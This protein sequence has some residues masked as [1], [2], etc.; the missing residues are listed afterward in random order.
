MITGD[1]NIN[2]RLYGFRTGMAIAAMFFYAIIFALRVLYE[3]YKSDPLPQISLYKAPPDVNA[4]KERVKQLVQN[5]AGFDGVICDG[6]S[7]VFMKS[8]GP[9][10]AVKN[11]CFAVE[12]GKCFGLLGK[13][14]AGKTTALNVMTG[15][16]PATSG[17]GILNSVAT[18]WDPTGVRKQSG[19]CPQFQT[20]WLHFTVYQHLYLA[21]S[22]KG[23]PLCELDAEINRLCLEIGLTPYIS[24]RCGHLSGGNKRKLMLA[25]ALIGGAKVLF[26]DEPSA[27][28]D[29]VARSAIMEFIKS[30]KKDRVIIL[31]THQMEETEWLCDSIGIMVNGDF[32]AIGTK[33]QLIKMNASGYSVEISISGMT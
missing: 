4:E 12:N 25:T 32:K 18:N 26:L 5:P 16:M 8:T 7:K 19:V 23:V 15:M 21:G 20:M 1:G 14:G 9:F 22:L 29:P 30:Y 10:V 31:T 13:N 17:K 24:R 33:Q 11:L 27:G 28:M 3:Y 6:V 2:D